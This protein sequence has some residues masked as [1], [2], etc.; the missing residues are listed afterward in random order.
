MNLAAIWTHGVL[1]TQSAN[2]QGIRNER[3]VT[4]PAASTSTLG[5]LIFRNLILRSAGKQ[6]NASAA[7]QSEMTRK[8]W[9]KYS[10]RCQELALDL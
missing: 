5:A 4:A 6:L 1:G 2:Y 10:R 8:E 9:R 3:A 7:M